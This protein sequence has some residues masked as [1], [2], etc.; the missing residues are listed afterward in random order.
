MQ[1]PGVGFLEQLRFSSKSAVGA[2][3]LA[4]MVPLL[5]IMFLGW[6]STHLLVIYWLE[7]LVIGF[8]SVFR[9]ILAGE[10]TNSVAWIAALFTAVFFT[11]HFGA[12]CFGHGFFIFILTRILIPRTDLNQTAEVLPE[13]PPEDYWPFPLIFFQ[14]FSQPVFLLLKD[15]PTGWIVAFIAMFLSHGISFVTNF[16]LKGEW[17]N[18]NP[19]EQARAP[20]S[21]VVLL[22]IAV[23]LGVILSISFGASM[24]VMVVLVVGKTILDLRL[25]AKQHAKFALTPEHQQ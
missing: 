17:R 8:Y 7:N 25:H 22:H 15:A 2:L 11:L 9:I 10:K 3:V 16:L 5:G 12:F 14:I 23:I 6:D 19:G 1:F 20:Y 18:T 21:R 4:N 13:I 24:I